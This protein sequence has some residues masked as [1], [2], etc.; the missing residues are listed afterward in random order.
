M[1]R[2][3]ALIIG[4]LM[5]AGCDMATAGTVTNKWIQPAHD[6]IWFVCAGYDSK[7]MCTVNVPMIDH[8][9]TRYIVEFHNE[10][11]DE[12]GSAYVDEKRYD[13]IQVGQWYP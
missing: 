1:K 13:G 7:G 12:D 5:L 2:I 11:E 4:C 8:I 10:A 6:D 3:A 9:P